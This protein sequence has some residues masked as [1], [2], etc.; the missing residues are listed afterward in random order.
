MSWNQHGQGSRPTEIWPLQPMYLKK[1]LFRRVIYLFC[2][3]NYNTYRSTDADLS[4]FS[5]VFA[6]CTGFFVPPCFIFGGMLH[7]NSAANILVGIR[8][9]WKSLRYYRERER[10]LYGQG[11]SD[12]NEY[13][14]NRKNVLRKLYWRFMFT[15]P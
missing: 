2:S 13:N 11:K 12:V 14:Q 4:Q 15:F 5:S 1:T 8:W 9:K 7:C 6:A 3:T 10:E